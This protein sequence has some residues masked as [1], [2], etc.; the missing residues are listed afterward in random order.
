MSVM[1]IIALCFG[2]M[3]LFG[4][5]GL[6]KTMPAMGAGRTDHIWTWKE[7]FVIDWR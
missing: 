1:P 3:F 7:L 4:F 2:I 6:L 5:I